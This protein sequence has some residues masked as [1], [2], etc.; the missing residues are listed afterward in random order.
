MMITLKYSPK[1]EKL[2][3]ARNDTIVSDYTPKTESNIAFSSE[4]VEEAN[5]TKE[6]S[7]SILNNVGYR[8]IPSNLIFLLK[9]EFGFLNETQEEMEMIDKMV[10][11][12]RDPLTAK[13]QTSHK[14][15]RLYTF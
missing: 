12:L 1:K 11:T 15:S 13:N 6:P 14:V 10:F 9:R 8:N 4:R 3:Q 5:N 7:H 2:Q